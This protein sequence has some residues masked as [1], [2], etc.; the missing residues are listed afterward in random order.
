MSKIFEK[1][2]QFVKL[3]LNWWTS[4]KREFPWRST[5]D[6]YSI[7]IAEMLLR[8]TTAKQV[9]KIYTQFLTKYPDPNS[10]A[11]ADKNELEE[12]LK[13]LGMEYKRA[14]LLK[15][16]GLYIK[17]NYDGKIPL[18][19]KKLLKLPGI[20]MYAANAVLSF[21]CS[22][23][24]PLL[25]TNFIRVINRVFGIKSQKSR[26]R[27]D[28]KIWEFA[29]TLIPSNN[30]KNFNLAVLDFAALIC[31]AKKPK[32][33]ECPVKN[34]CFYYAKEGININNTAVFGFVSFLFNLILLY[35]KSL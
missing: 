17:E 31:K 13:P 23:D 8:K 15:K 27:D 25:D 19:L 33:S 20:G 32:C 26:A 6:P 22:K 34:I 3:L 7:L 29:Q 14:E 30:S 18:E 11:D 2:N 4:N 1:K 5:K 24:V 28:K 21:V 12:L 35:L 10:L 9:E 16:F